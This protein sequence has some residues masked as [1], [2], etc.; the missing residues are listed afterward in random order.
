MFLMFLFLTKS[1]PTLVLGNSLTGPTVRLLG[2]AR[3]TKL[4]LNTQEIK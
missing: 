4:Q 3:G 2:F 1:M